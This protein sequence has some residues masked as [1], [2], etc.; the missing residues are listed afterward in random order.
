MPSREQRRTGRLLRYR[1]TL[2]LRA[3]GRPATIAELLTVLETLGHPVE[4]RPSKTVSD[5]LRQEVR[6][7]RVRRAAR[8]TYVADRIPESTVRWMQAYLDP[9][10][11]GAS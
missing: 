11:S 2:A 4:G 5:A 7:G 6:R 10:S 3:L 8:A 9:T 1:L